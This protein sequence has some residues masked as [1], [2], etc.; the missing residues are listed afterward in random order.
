MPA[1]RP[2]EYDYERLGPLIEEY[3]NKC[4]D[5]VEEYHKTRGEKSD[6]YER[7]VRVKLPTIEGLALYLGID[8]TTVYEWEKTYAEFSHDV[9]RV[10]A[11]QAERLINSGLSGDYNPMIAKV[12]L[13]KHGYNDKTDINL[14]DTS[15]EPTDDELRDAITA[16]TG[17]SKDASV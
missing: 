1:G 10:R 7:L 8:K 12:L 14:R 15:E 4:V 17:G 16:S 9:K 3:I 11:L 6:S 5:E 2:I 13:T